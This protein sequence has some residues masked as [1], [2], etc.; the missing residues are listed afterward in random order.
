MK[1]SLVFP[2]LLIYIIYRNI[3]IIFISHFS[4][5]NH[6]GAIPALLTLGLVIV[7]SLVTLGLS[8]LTNTNK[9]ASNPRAAT[10]STVQCST[11]L[12]GS[13][14]SICYQSP[15]Y[16]SGACGSTGCSG[17]TYSNG[18]HGGCTSGEGDGAT[19]CSGQCV[20]SS[21][22][23]PGSSLAVPADG[24]SDCSPTDEKV[25][26]SNDGV[27]TDAG[28]TLTCPANDSVRQ[29]GSGSNTQC[30]DICGAV[31][32]YGNDH[33]GTFQQTVGNTKYCCCNKS[34]ANSGGGGDRCCLTKA[35][36][37]SCNGF[38]L[39]SIYSES[40]SQY[41]IPLTSCD[42]DSAYGGTLNLCDPQ[43]IT[44]GC[45]DDDG[46]N[47]GSQGAV[48]DTSDP[49]YNPTL[50]KQKNY[51]TT[52]T[53]A[54]CK[55][56]GT[57]FQDCRETPCSKNGLTACAGGG[58]TGDLRK[59]PDGVTAAICTFGNGDSNSTGPGLC[60]T[61]TYNVKGCNPVPSNKNCS[62]FN[63]PDEC[64]GAIVGGSSCTWIESTQTCAPIGVEASGCL[65]GDTAECL[66]GPQTNSSG[67]ALCSQ[68]GQYVDRSIN[69]KSNTFTGD[70]TIYNVGQCN[71]WKSK[72]GSCTWDNLKGC[73]NTSAP[74][75]Q[76][77]PASCGSPNYGCVTGDPNGCGQPCGAASILPGNGKC[78]RC[79]GIGCDPT[80]LNQ[81]KTEA[82]NMEVGIS[83]CTQ[84]GV[85]PQSSQL[86]IVVTLD[87]SGRNIT[88]QDVNDPEGMFG[89]TDQNGYG[90]TETA[91]NSLSYTF[92]IQSTQGDVFRAKAGYK[93]TDKTG[94]LDHWITFP[95][96][97]SL[98]NPGGVN[99]V[100]TFT[101]KP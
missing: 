64:L 29:Q 69:C 23:K 24:W 84:G 63:G 96:G 2:S 41:D 95:S 97:N 60:G 62:D 94:G 85:A 33:N 40:L 37:K 92:N 93:T 78:Y 25:C 42:G 55:S 17:T 31:G 10:C 3:E 32:Y 91:K 72:N 50:C 100:L 22:C 39:I 61:A 14:G 34:A 68:S 80:H 52:S 83:E 82:S 18:W 44:P 59:C 70:C 87:L 73:I 65:P 81:N 12:T 56:D 13:T 4:M 99:P 1:I 47:V 71:Y 45:Y 19:P 35:K 28:V 20:S 88:D 86:T 27:I 49:S 67:P 16:Y 11:L 74:P 101:I 98:I 66:F 30:S 9:I 77:Y 26:C 90:Q 8:V 54:C 5:K 57:T 21:Q 58:S 38:D 48:Y 75:A 7:G 15:D 43:D 79:M 53:Y 36:H 51:P 46:N 89:Y 76:V 6:K